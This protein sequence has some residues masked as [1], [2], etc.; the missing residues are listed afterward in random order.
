VI[1]IYDSKGH[2][3]TG[4]TSTINLT[5]SGGSL[6]YC[7]GLTPNYG[8]VDVTTCSFLGTV[9]QPYT[10]TASFT[11]SQG[12][13]ISVQSQPITPRV[14][15]PRRPSRSP[16]SRLAE[17]RRVVTRHSAEPADCGLVGQR[18]NVVVGND[19]LTTTP[20]GGTLSNCGNL[21]AVAGVVNATGCTFAAR[22]RL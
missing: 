6:P 5:P 12:T 20:S 15:V 8:V 3:D 7:T 10:L 4:L 9:G 13:V 14:P 19:L 17:R 21:T 11:N 22:S 18:R 2:I 16:L 1:T